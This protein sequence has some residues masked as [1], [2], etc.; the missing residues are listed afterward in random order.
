MHVSFGPQ[1]SAGQAHSALAATT[2]PLKP[3]AGVKRTDE[4]STESLNILRKKGYKI[5][6][7]LCY[8]LFKFIIH[9]QK[10]MNNTLYHYLSVGIVT[11]YGLGGRVFNPG[12]GK[13]FLFSPRSKLALEP[14]LP[15][16]QWVP[17]AIFSEVKQPKPDAD[18]LPPSI[19][20]VQNGGSIPPLPYMSLW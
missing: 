16:I 10:E 15:P 3:L 20:E 1:N 13:I 7:N 11:G 8:T 17:R 14:T 19:A 4:K 9:F 5:L 18:H 6:Y 2:S 12:R